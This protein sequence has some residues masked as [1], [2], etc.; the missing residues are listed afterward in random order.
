MILAQLAPLGQPV[1][2]DHKV[3]K[4]IREQPDL[5]VLQDQREIPVLLDQPDQLDRPVL[6]DPQDLPVLAF[7]AEQE[8]QVR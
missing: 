8:R 1:Q 2:R 6:L 7:S 4:A 3:F 5:P